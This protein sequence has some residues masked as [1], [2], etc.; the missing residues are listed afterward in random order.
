MTAFRSTRL[1]ACLAA[2]A[3]FAIV[4]APT[5]IAASP[6][7][8]SVSVFNTETVQAYLDATGKLTEARI[9]DQIAL[10]GNGKVELNNPVSM[11][12]LRNLDG[13]GGFDT[14]DGAIVGTYSVDGQKRLRAVSTYTHEL[15]LEVA[16]VYELDGK[17]VKPGDVVGKSG[18][19]KVQYTVKNLTGEQREVPVTGP[20]GT[21]LNV[22]EDVVIP[23]VGSLTT[24]LPS[25]FTD[26]S[27]NEA[28]MAG[29]GRGGTK[30]SFTMTLF[31]PIGKP[32][33]TFGY[34]AKIA[35]GVIPRAS[36]SALPVN[37]LASPSF[38]GG[39]AS[40]QSGA[41]SGATLYNGAI[42]I[43]TNLLKLRDGA[44]QLLA[45]LI[46][47][48]D[49]ATQLETG[50]AGSAAPGAQRLADGA[51]QLK[52]GSGRLAA[53][54]GTAAAGSNKL[55]DGSKTLAAGAGRLADGTKQVDAGAGQLAA[56]LGQAGQSAPALIDGLDQVQDG[57][58][59]VDAGLAQLYGGIGQLPAQAQPLHDGIADLKAGIGSTSA[60]GTLLFGVDQVRSGLA[61]ATAPGASLDQLKGGANQLQAGADAALAPGGSIDQAEGGIKS[62]KSTPGCAGD[63]VCLGTVDAVAGQIKSNMTASAGQTSGGAGQISGGLGELKGSLQGAVTGLTRVQC[64]LSNQSL[65]GVCDPSKPGL[66][67][68]LGALD[69]GVTQLVNTVVATVQGGVGKATDTKAD[70]TLRGGVHGLQDGVGQIQAGGTA[71]LH[72]LAQLTDGAVTLKG[73]TGQ[74]ATG[75]RDLAAGSNTLAAGAGD[76]STGLGT[77]AAGT[78][79]LDAGAGTLAAGAGTLAGGLGDAAR[80]SSQIADGLTQAAQSAPKL[81]DGAQQLSDKGMSKLIDAGEATATDYGT[82][83]ALI[84][85]GAQRAQTE[86][87]AYGAPEGAVGATAYS[88]ELAGADG[89][90]GRNVARLLG[91]AAIF[92]LAGGAAVMRRRKA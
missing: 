37:P 88:I 83:F 47:L 77:L 71:L 52:D 89:Q 91:A 30:M 14:K 70:G 20:D 78:N 73:G 31:G 62:I 32:E 45:G 43:D 57:L 58:G 18:L 25:N 48:R 64:G 6:G 42:E 17:E 15:P 85:A 53:G 69:A 79:T 68:G 61:A 46:K 38:K 90:G 81:E 54:A 1:A 33:A 59:L 8:G 9:Y 67:E 3:A 27:S 66:L 82:K 63:P 74:L 36:I 51:A 50:L 55:A 76:L 72:G 21:P 23:M 5:A 65:S 2:P 22:S 13:F 12:G 80:G 40:Y 87:M 86:D 75:S 44:G 60:D 49:G 56:G 11:K 34:T 41:E 16:V 28:N 24:T 19:L 84:E 92:G 4:V 39:A 35:D 10:Q 29:D 7:D 26:V